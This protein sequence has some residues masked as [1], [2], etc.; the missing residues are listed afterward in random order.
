MGKRPTFVDEHHLQLGGHDF[1]CAFPLSDPPAG[2]LQVEKPRDLVE[3]YIAIIEEVQPKRI[4]ELG[5]RRGGSTALLSELARPEKLV[6][7]EIEPRLPSGLS[8][9]LEQSGRRDIVR[10]YCGVD[11]SDRTRLG[12]IVAEEFEGNSLDLVIDDASHYYEQTLASF[13]VLFPHLRPGG[14]FIIED[15]QWE[16]R[17]SDGLAASLQE[18]SAEVRAEATRAVEEATARGPRQPPLTRL[19]IAL[20]LACA[21]SSDAVQELSA[22]PHWVVV[23]RGPGALDPVTFR[24][25]DLFHDHY[26]LL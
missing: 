12:G 7:V 2:Y 16:H 3:R 17:L 24:V 14:L 20:L 6:A 21:S 1:Y 19:V 9:Y 8:R 11:Q 23:R 25:A 5:I 22:G 4:V 26:D 10:A 18:S 13:E 15:W